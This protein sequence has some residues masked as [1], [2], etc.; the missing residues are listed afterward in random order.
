MKA[1]FIPDLN[2][3]KENNAEL[4]K[5][6]NAKDEDH[7]LINKTSDITKQELPNGYYFD[8]FKLNKSVMLTDNVTA[9]T[10]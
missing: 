3:V 4:L 5:N 10:Q 9:E 8:R 2:H 6:W 7:E 1:P